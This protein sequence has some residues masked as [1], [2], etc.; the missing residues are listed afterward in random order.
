MNTIHLCEYVNRFP[1]SDFLIVGKGP[2][3]YAYEKLAGHTGPM[4]FINETVRMEH[5]ATASPETFFFAHDSKQKAEVHARTRSTV[6]MPRGPAVNPRSGRKMLSDDMLGSLPPKVVPYW[7]G[8][9]WSDAELDERSRQWVAE[10]ERLYQHSGTIHT[11]MHFAWLCGAAKLILVGCSGDSK[12]YD[13]RLEVSYGPA[14]AGVYRKIRGQQDR[15]GKL[16]NMEIEY[17]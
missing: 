15:M 16:L 4:A 5:L 6:V 10:H 17:R 2:T 9:F 1:G 8:N 13:P 3:R 12:G 7:Y 11:A 14:R